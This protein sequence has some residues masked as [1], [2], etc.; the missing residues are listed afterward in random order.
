MKE[1]IF[2]LLMILFTIYSLLAENNTKTALVLSG[3]GAKGFAQIGM[4]KVLDECD[5]KVDYI[6]GSS[7]GAVI[8]GL[9]AAGFSALEIERIVLTIDWT[10]ILDDSVSRR[11]LIA[12]QKRWLPTG[13]IKLELDERSAPSLPQGLILANNIHLQLFYETWQVAHIKDFSGLPIDF[14]CVATDLETGELVLLETGSLADAM[15]ASSSIPGIFLPMQLNGRLLV[16]GGIT[17]NLPADIAYELGSDFIIAVRTNTELS[18]RENLKNPIQ[19]LNQTLNIGQKYR[20]SFAEQYANISFT[21]NT[22]DFQILDFTSAKKIIDIGYQE[23]LG[24][25][26]RLKAA[27]LPKKEVKLVEKMPEYIKFKRIIVENNI[28]LSQAAIR[29]Y[30]GLSRNTMYNRNELLHAFKR[31]YSSELFDIIYPNIIVEDDEF[32]LV[33]HVKERERRSLS[34]NLIYNEHEGLVVGTILNMRNV[35]LKNSNLFVHLNM[36]GRNAI[37]IDYSKYISYNYPIY[38]RLFPYVKQDK[39]YLYNDDFKRERSYKI[40][41]FGATFGIGFNLLK[42]ASLEPFLYYYN[43]EFK[44]DVGDLDIFEEAIYSTGGGVKIYYEYFDDYPYYKR[45]LSFFSKYAVA[46]G[47]EVSDLGYRKMISSAKAA[48]PLNKNLSFLIFTEYG[49]YFKSEPV[50]EDPFYIGGLDSF[51]G[52]NEKELLA[53]FYRTISSGFRI[54]PYQ[55]LFFDLKGSYLTYG[56]TD[57]WFEMDESVA[58]IGLI[59]GYKKIFRVPLPIRFGLGL[60]DS[61]RFFTYISIGYDYDAFFFS[62]R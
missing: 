6:I 59:I 58:S 28:Y 42:H 38:Y 22:S 33:V 44:Q 55:N 27:N 60:N 34:A 53:P 25:V 43:I 61:D 9:Y 13:N 1:T 62:R 7:I 47:N 17:Q 19:I 30:L 48:I 10:D 41:E 51:M 16:D 52:L 29:D 11:D 46:P 56:P 5:I 32:V 20:Q 18:N 2:F 45:G 15:R 21:P 36:G 14:K 50:Q 40:N 12:Q 31:A 26:D 3:G 23:A 35:V 39:I 57:K 37:E 8:G 54:N 4:L 49:T 24:Y